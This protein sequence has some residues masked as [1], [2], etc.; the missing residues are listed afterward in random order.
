MLERLAPTLIYDITIVGDGSLP[1]EQIAAVTVPTLVIDGEKSPA[2]AQNAV[3]A[4]A[5]ALPKGQH[6]T[7]AGQTHNVAPDALAPVVIEFCTAL[8]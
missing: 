6:R 7:L 2:W 8:F 4:L 3:Q 1:I 5:E